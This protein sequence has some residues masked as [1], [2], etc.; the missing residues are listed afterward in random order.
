[1]IVYVK[2]SSGQ[3]YASPVFAEIG[4]GWGI[5]S[6]VLNESGD[7]LVLMPLLE[8]QSGTLALYNYFYIDESLQDGWINGG[9]IRGFAEIIK[10]QTDA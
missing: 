8:R 9:K 1:M 2:P 7:A 5:K 4:K 3:I 6:V 10:K